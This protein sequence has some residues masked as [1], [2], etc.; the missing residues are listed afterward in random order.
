MLMTR[1][2]GM[3]SLHCPIAI[4]GLDCAETEETKAVKSNKKP[5]K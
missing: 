3:C 1:L 5:R 4:G 2:Y